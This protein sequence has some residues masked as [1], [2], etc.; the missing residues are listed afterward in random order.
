MPLTYKHNLLPTPA[1]IP[2]GGVLGY[3]YSTSVL[4]I[5]AS[6]IFRGSDRRNR[7]TP[8]LP[9]GHRR[10]HVD[11]AVQRSAIALHHQA[12]AQCRHQQRAVRDVRVT[13]TTTPSPPAL[14]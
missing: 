12:P 13:N 2:T 14:D 11:P 8:P 5:G 1:L 7:P 6:P 10:S 9:C 3:S 4:V